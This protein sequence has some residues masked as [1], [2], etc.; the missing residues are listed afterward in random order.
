M[1]AQE[2]FIEIHSFC[3]SNTDE[4]KIKKYSRYFKDGYHGYGVP[5][6]LYDSKIRALLDYTELTLDLVLQSAPLLMK[7]GMYEE[8]SFVIALSLHFQNQFTRK[9][10]ES[11]ESWFNYGIKNWAHT[12]YLS[13]ELMFIF[14]RKGIIDFKDLS[15][16]RKAKNKFQRRAV[17]VSMIKLLKTTDHYQPFFAFI[18]PMMT[19]PEREVH[20]GL[21]WFLREAWKKQKEPTE[22]FLLKWK[23]TAPRLIFQYAT[24]KM[25]PEEKQRFRKE[26]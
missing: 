21:G 13:G 17:P 12:D 15:K 26:K 16:W 20:Q 24:E 7:T 4:A 19:D 3:E 10:F 9:T 22:I 8:T 23:N 5:K 14:F 18:D 6:E 2:L 1:T 11:I 25:T